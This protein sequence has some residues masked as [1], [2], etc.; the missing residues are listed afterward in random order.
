VGGDVKSTDFFT[1]TGAVEGYGWTGS[2]LADY[3]KK[4]DGTVFGP[5]STGGGQTVVGKV[6]GHQAADMSKFAQQRD[7]IIEQIKGQKKADRISLLKD[8][9]LTELIKKGKVK[10]HEAVINRLI[11][12]YRSS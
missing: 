1:V 3:F 7:T 11:A 8:S 9:I 2:V 12:Q 5:L 6:T 4:P 10:R